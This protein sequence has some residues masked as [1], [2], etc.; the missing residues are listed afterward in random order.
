MKSLRKTIS[1]NDSDMDKSQCLFHMDIS[2]WCWNNDVKVIDDVIYLYFL[3]EM[4]I[5]MIAMGV[6]G[7]GCYLQV[8][9]IIH[10]SYILN[11]IYLLFIKRM[12]GQ[13]VH[14]NF[15]LE[16]KHFNKLQ[17]TWNKLDCFIVISG[18]E[19]YHFSSDHWSVTKPVMGCWD[20]VFT[21]SK[22]TRQ[23]LLMVIFWYFWG[24]NQTS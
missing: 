14:S 10:Q 18:W 2:R 3:G 8:Q 16:V 4:I 19:K 15:H 13:Y 17:E 6:M 23:K 20:E 24:V 1:T 12:I 11:F 22:V 21:V 9:L 5:K 7:R